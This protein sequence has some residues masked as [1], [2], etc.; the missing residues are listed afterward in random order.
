MHDPIGR[1]RCWDC[2]APQD[3]QIRRLEHPQRLALGASVAQRI[4][5]VIEDRVDRRHN[6]SV[7][8][9][10]VSCSPIGTSATGARLAKIDMVVITIGR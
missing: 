3:C 2:E 9:V 8:S 4:L 10:Q 6:T 5:H 7:S 1:D